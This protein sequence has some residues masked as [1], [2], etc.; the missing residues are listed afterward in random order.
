MTITCENV[1]NNMGVLHTEAN[2]YEQM[3]AQKG[4]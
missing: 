2:I 1:E 4:E 3:A